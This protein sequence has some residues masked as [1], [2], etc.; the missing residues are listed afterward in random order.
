MKLSMRTICACILG[1]AVLAA[2]GAALYSQ[3]A[4]RRAAT[5]PK[6]LHSEEDYETRRKKLLVD[7]YTHSFSADMVLSAAETNV[8]NI[9]NAVRSNAIAGYKLTGNFPPSKPFFNVRTNIEQS[10]L[11]PILKRMPKGGLLHVHDSA[12]GRCAFVVTNI[13]RRSD[14]YIY[15]DL[16]NKE[17]PLGQLLFTNA[18]PSVSGAAGFFPAA[19]LREQLRA[20]GTD[21]DT[22]LFNRYMLDS[23]DAHTANIWQAFGNWWALLPTLIEYRPVF[24]DY[25][26][27]AFRTLHED[28]IS[29]V[30]LRVMAPAGTMFD[31]DAR[32]LLNT[33]YTEEDT[34]REYVAARDFVRTNFNPLFSLKI[35]LTGYRVVPELDPRPVLE[36][37][38]RYRQTFPDLIVGCDWVGEEDGG[39]PTL[40]IAPALRAVAKRNDEHRDDPI[41]FYFHDG[42]TAWPGNDNLIDA[43]LLGTKR[44]GHGY[45]LFHL[46]T[47]ERMVRDKRIAIEVCPISNQLLH[48]LP[49]LRT[50]PA[51]GYMNRGIPC[52]LGSDDPAI[53]G[54]DGL[55]YDF[56][57]AYFAWDLDLSDLKQLAE[58]SLTY[59]ALPTEEM[60]AARARWHQQW[61]AWIQWV[62]SQAATSNSPSTPKL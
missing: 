36:R 42:E 46:P 22:E 3:R 12:V 50:H 19:A 39:Q 34:V 4:A 47:L 59:S 40:S 1:L 6:A 17:G 24:R 52:V 23:S 53:M 27:D 20:A 31:Y 48:L 41:H 35:I 9:F 13:A 38:R 33:N 43:V 55:T 21:L 16:R 29:H 44:I 28:G 51:V 5:V 25:L 49:D 14:C 32:G 60:L 58:N 62:L 18:P 8:D 37:V 30:E 7:M 57:Q 10:P 61:D 54:N 45:N 2:L 26:Q 15:W 56:W 11:F